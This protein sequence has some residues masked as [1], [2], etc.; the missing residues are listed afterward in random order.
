MQTLKNTP[1]SLHAMDTEMDQEA[2]TE[3]DSEDTKIGEIFLFDWPE[4]M[5]RLFY[6]RAALRVLGFAA[7]DEIIQ[8]QYIKE[9]GMQ[10]DPAYPEWVHGHM[11]KVQESIDQLHTVA[12]AQKRSSKNREASIM[13]LQKSFNENCRRI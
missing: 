10:S 1:D 8:E 12:S 6:E 9:K 4:Y 2:D 3:M 7:A 5:K 11:Q 13:R